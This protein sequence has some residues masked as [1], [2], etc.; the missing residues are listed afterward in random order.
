M[1][2]I[3]IINGHE[4]Y[5]SSPG[6]LN[7]ELVDRAQQ[8]L[9]A[10]GYSVKTPKPAE[11]LDLEHE[12]NMH[13]WAD[14]II[15]QAPVNWM[16]V[17]WSMKRYIDLVAS[18]SFGQLWNGDGRSRENPAAQYGSGGLA[19]DKKYMLSL[20]FNAPEDAFNNSSQHFFAGQSVDDLFGHIHLVYKFMAMSALPTFVCYDVLKNPQID[21][22]FVRFGEHLNAAFPARNA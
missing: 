2:N 6:N 16:S 18:A 14:A 15:I 12:V 5:E 10:L 22:D 13:L 21:S 3:Y 9:Q 1:K 8:Q 4:P 7:R 17:P 11:N 19:S 20:T